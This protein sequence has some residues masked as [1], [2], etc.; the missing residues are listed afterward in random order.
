M[1]Y[2]TEVCKNGAK[3]YTKEWATEAQALRA[4]QAFATATGSTVRVV[5]L[6]RRDGVVL[7]R[8]ATGV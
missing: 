5:D 6:G 4:A 7:V 3:V 2:I 8:P 1:G